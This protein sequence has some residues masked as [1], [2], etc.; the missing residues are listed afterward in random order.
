MQHSML[1]PTAL[2]LS[3]HLPR[4]VQKNWPFETFCNYFYVYSNNFKLAV[5]MQHSM[6][7]PTELILSVHLPRLVQENWPFGPYRSYFLSYFFKTVSWRLY[8]EGYD[9]SNNFKLD[10]P[11]QHSMLKPTALMLSVHLP[12]FVLKNRPF[13]TYC[14]FFMIIHISS[15]LLFLCTIPCLNALILSVH[16]TRLFQENWLFETYYS[17]FLRLF[18]KNCKKEALLWRQ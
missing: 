3:V 18:S 17:Y 4:F 1:K 16:Q 6:F 5:P 13:E 2:V 7:K 15:N 14:S 8:C 11:M 10:V 12:R 9:C